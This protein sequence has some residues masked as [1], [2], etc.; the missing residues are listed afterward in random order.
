MPVVTV[1]TNTILTNIAVIATGNTFLIPSVE[2]TINLSNLTSSNNAITTVN[3]TNNIDISVIDQEPNTDI[4]PDVA[5]LV[6]VPIKLENTE[7]LPIASLESHVL[8]SV[9]KD[10]EILDLCYSILCNMKNILWCNRRKT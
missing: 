8:K 3:I 4:T 6:G 5:P 9:N 2:Y 7:Y 1:S 10:A